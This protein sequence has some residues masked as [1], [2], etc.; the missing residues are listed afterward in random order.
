M[1]LDRVQVVNVEVLDG[2][3]HLTFDSGLHV[4]I[5]DSV[6]NRDSIRAGNV[7]HI[8]YVETD[9]FAEVQAFRWNISPPSCTCKEE[10]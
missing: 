1:T 5:A 2:R 4:V 7:I 8:E 6:P 9:G 3:T 10:L